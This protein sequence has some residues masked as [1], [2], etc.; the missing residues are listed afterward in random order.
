MAGNHSVL[1]HYH[2]LKAQLAYPPCTQTSMGCPRIVLP[3]DPFSRLNTPHLACIC[4]PLPNTGTPDLDSCWHFIFKPLLPRVFC[5]CLKRIIMLDMC[6]FL[7]YVHVHLSR[8]PR[9]VSFFV[10][11]ELI[12]VREG[13][14]SS[15]IVSG[16]I[17][18][19]MCGK[20]SEMRFLFWFPK[21]FKV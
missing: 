3:S 14:W 9:A 4:H 21:S 13:W 19:I 1:I 16:F 20:C 5:W 11:A 15:F 17:Y 2:R 12:T 7:I 6:Q 10:L 8:W 18:I